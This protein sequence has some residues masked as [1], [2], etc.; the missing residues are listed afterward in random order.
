MCIIIYKTDQDEIC[1]YEVRIRVSALCVAYE[2]NISLGED[3]LSQS[4]WPSISIVVYLSE[5]AD[6]MDHAISTAN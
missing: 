4:V 3:T 6:N 2:E 5:V 1:I